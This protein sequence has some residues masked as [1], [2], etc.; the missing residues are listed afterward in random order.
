MPAPISSR[1]IGN[2]SSPGVL[3]ISA[4]QMVPLMR[5]LASRR[6]LWNERAVSSKPSGSTV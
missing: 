6:P 5:A 4:S 1:L 2:V 3:L